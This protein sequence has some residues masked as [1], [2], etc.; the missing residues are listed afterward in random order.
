MSAW[1]I[2]HPVFSRKGLSPDL[3][4]SG[5]LFELPNDFGAELHLNLLEALHK[6]ICES[7][8]ITA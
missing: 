5:Y 6:I 1:T 4:K 2:L 3:T 7:C 8:R